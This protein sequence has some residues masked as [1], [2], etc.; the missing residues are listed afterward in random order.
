MANEI[1]TQI[2]REAPEIEAFKIGL[3]QEAKDLYGKPMN[4]PA[5]QTAGL[6]PGQK[7]AAELARQGIGAWQP[8]IEAAEQSV[9]AGMGVTADAANSFQGA[10][11]IGRAHV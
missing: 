11:E 3:L 10:R 1:S 7:Q 9:V 4:L 8:N 2:V 6:S 5:I